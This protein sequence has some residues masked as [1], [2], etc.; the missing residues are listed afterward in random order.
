MATLTL[1]VITPDRIALDQQVESVRLTAVDGSLGVLPRHAPMVAALAP[2]LVTYKSG[3]RTGVLFCS[4]GF[5]EV[6]ADT[7]RVVTPASEKSEEIDE[8]RAREA[9]RRARERLDQGR[10]QGGDPIDMVRAEAAL[11]RALLR[12]SARGYAP[13]G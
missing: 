10:A 13:E 11:R 3:G 8:A 1:R 9:E 6:H 7:L 4:G 5:A 2:G 12:L